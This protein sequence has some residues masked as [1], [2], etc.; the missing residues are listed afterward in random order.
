M[1]N[2]GDLDAADGWIDSWQSGIEQR[3]AAAR[4]LSDRLRDLTVTA[5][6]RDTLVQ[7]TV[8]SAGALVALEL[9]DEI[10]SRSAAGIA[11]AILSTIG[12]ASDEVTRQIRLATEQTVGRGSPTGAAILEA[13][14]ASDPDGR[15][16]R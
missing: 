8:N 15:R 6:S 12:S 1:F 16:D 14:Q 9:R 7:V 13:Y 5:E 10:R 2:E 4:E 3:A 11:E